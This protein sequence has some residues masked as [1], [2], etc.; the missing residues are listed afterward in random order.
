MNIVVWIVTGLLAAIFL[1][2]GIT[3]LARSKEQLVGNSSMAWAEDFSPGLLKV[4][5]GCE[6]AAAIG[7][8]LPA[9]TGIATW[10]VPT[11]AVGLA[12][13][14]VGAAITHLR[15]QEYLNIVVNLVLLTLALFVAIQVHRSGRDWQSDLNW[16]PTSQAR[17]NTTPAN[18][19]PS[20]SGH[21]RE[22]T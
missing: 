15:R 21:L 2:T 10:L 4:I 3:K 13:V 6:V 22:A 16:S 11:A 8:V 9:L 20:Q 5:G 7:L 14:M 17:S 19:K 18:V 12:L 1:L